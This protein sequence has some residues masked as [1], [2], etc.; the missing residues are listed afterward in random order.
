MPPLPYWANCRGVPIS[1][2]DVYGL[3]PL[4]F[5]LD[6][7]QAIPA[8]YPLLWFY[9]DPADLKKVCS[10]Q[11]LAQS[12]LLSAELYINLSGVSYSLKAAES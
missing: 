6:S 2:A 9:L 11:L 7:A 10:L 5:A 1:F 12:H 8:G 3:L 4:G